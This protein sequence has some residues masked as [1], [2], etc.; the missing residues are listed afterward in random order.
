MNVGRSE[1]AKLLA[2][3]A[4]VVASPIISKHICLVSFFSYLHMYVRIVVEDADASSCEYLEDLVILSLNS[5]D[6]LF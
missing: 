2:R 1:K 4:Y 6:Q 3:S 5:G